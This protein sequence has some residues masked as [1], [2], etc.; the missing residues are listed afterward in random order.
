MPRI[1]QLNVKLGEV[2]DVPR[3]ENHSILNGHGGDLGGGCGGAAASAVTVAHE[4]SPDS[5]R[6][7][8]ERQDAPIELSGKVLLDP[9]LESF[10][11]LRLLC[12]PGAPNE[13]SDG[14]GGEEE[15]RLLRPA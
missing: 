11:T 4:A 3:H 2:P 5:G 6:A 9:S 13:F 10:A 8:I 1:E 12:L 7:D 15:I 14:L